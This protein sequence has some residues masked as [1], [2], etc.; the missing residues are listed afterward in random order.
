[1][2]GQPSQLSTLAQNTYRHYQAF[3]SNAHKLDQFDQLLDSE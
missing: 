3:L 1:L 2:A